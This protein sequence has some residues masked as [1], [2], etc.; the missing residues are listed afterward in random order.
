ME[1]E[2]K[3]Q[4]PI[5]QATDRQTRRSVSILILVLVAYAL[6]VIP[7]VFVAEI[8]RY[9]DTTVKYGEQQQQPIVQA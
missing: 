9:L 1:N 2:E 4:H 5:V 3:Q 7:I 8:N 6:H